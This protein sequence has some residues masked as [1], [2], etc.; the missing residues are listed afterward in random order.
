MFPLSSVYPMHFLNSGYNSAYP[1]LGA[2]ALAAMLLIPAFG[3]ETF[4]VE[5]GDLL[6]DAAIAI[7]FADP[8]GSSKSYIVSV[9]GE[10]AQMVMCKATLKSQLPIVIRGLRAQPEF[11]G[12][13]PLGAQCVHTREKPISAYP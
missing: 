10:L 12:K 11:Q 5:K 6:I 3:S 1:L 13:K 4:T 2:V 9:N 7:Q 8:D